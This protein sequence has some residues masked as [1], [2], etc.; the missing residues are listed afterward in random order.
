MLEDSE[1]RCVHAELQIDRYTTT[2]NEAWWR[3]LWYNPFRV[4]NPAEKNAYRLVLSQSLLGESGHIERSSVL[5]HLIASLLMAVYLGVR[6]PFVQ[7]ETV[8]SDLAQGAIMLGTLTFVVST[9]YHVQSGTLSI[10]WILRILDHVS[11][12]CTM[13]FSNVTDLSLS[14]ATFEGEDW[15]VIADPIASA[16]FAIVLFL[17]IRVYRPLSTSTIAKGNCPLGL[18]RIEQHDGDFA[19]SRAQCYLCVAL[20]F[21]LHQGVSFRRLRLAWLALASQIV[22][23]CILVSGMIVDTVVEF[24]DRQYPKYKGLKERP[25]WWTKLHS[26]KYGCVCHSHALWH[27]AALLAALVTVVT[28]DVL[29]NSIAF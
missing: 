18:F 5:T 14:I 4:T 27:V 28:R 20:Y 11:I 19:P 23:F 22:T 9:V 1:L 12:M 24:P 7:T 6:R 3:V 13:A 10:Q 25:F 29:L 17:A 21:V 2:F 15:R 16:T 8:S 26:K